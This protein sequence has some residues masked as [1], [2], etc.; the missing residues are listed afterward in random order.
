MARSTLMSWFMA[1]APLGYESF[2]PRSGVSIWLPTGKIGVMT[3]KVL[4]SLT[5]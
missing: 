1:K 2:E 4:G 3:A 5:G